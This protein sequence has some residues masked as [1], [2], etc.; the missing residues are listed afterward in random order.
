MANKRQFTWVL[1]LVQVKNV[2]L[3]LRKAI[4]SPL[5]E[6]TIDG[7]EDVIVNVTGGLDMTLT[8]AEKHLKLLVKQL[9]AVLTF[10]L[11]HQSMIH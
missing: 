10:G 7:A 8:E 9:V 3:K 2:L 6:T 5:L 4:Y 1:V 11:V